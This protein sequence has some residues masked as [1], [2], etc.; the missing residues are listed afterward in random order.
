MV[1]FFGYNSRNLNRDEWNLEYNWGAPVHTHT[2]NWGKLPQEVHLRV[3]KQCFVFFLSHNQRGF[4]TTYTAPVSTIFKTKDAN[5]CLNAYTGEK[6]PNFCMGFFIPPKQPKRGNFDGCLWSGYSSFG[7]ISY[8][9]LHRL[10]FC[11]L[12][13]SSRYENSSYLMNIHRILS[14]SQLCTH[15]CSFLHFLTFRLVLLSEVRP[16][17]DNKKVILNISMSS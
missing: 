10:S 1:Q 15:F 17:C 16:D 5:R 7:T 6:F 11:A 3:P 8:F 12:Y 13:Y 14:V 4:S 9:L 2:K